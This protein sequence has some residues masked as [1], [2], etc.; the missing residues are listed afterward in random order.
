MREDSIDIATLTKKE[1]KLILEFLKGKKEVTTDE[2]RGFMKSH[3]DKFNLF[4]YCIVIHSRDYFSIQRP[5][6]L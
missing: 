4:E 2:I 1:Q 6:G 3:F 5:M